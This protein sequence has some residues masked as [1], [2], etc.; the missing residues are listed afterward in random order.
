MV[1][2]SNSPA[3]LPIQPSNLPANTASSPQGTVAGTPAQPNDVFES[4]V[5]RPFKNGLVSRA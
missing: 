2:I 3:N 1:S 4:L 5:T